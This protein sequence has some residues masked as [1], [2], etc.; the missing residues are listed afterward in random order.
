MEAVET[1]KRISGIDHMFSLSLHELTAC[2][3]YKLAIDRGLRGC[4]PDGEFRSHQIPHTDPLA[5]PDF[6]LGGRA[7]Q[8][9]ILYYAILCYTILYYTKLYYTILYY[10]KLYYT[11][12]YY[13]TLYYTILYNVKP[14]HIKLYH[15]YI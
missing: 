15:T 2:I 3:Y 8:C 10:T 4:D 14:Y 13:T 9:Y 12:L 7:S 11:I 1:L 5:E 6:K